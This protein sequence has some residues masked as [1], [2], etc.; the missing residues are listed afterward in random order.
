M[1][2]DIN[3]IYTTRYSCPFLIRFN[4]IQYY[5]YQTPENKARKILLRGL[6]PEVTAEIGLSELKHP[7]Y[8]TIHVRQLR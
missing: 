2:T 4:K 5:T 3:N 7:E 8:P 1:T 6:T